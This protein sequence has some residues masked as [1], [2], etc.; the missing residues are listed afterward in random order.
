MSAM[1]LMKAV[2]EKIREIRVHLETK[3]ESQLPITT[4]QL[5]EE[6]Q[7]VSVCINK[8]FFS[9]RQSIR[10]SILQYTSVPCGRECKCAIAKRERERGRKRERIKRGR[11][12]VFSYQICI[13]ALNEYHLE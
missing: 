13:S 2:N 5:E 3:L 12:E 1:R 6:L 4:Y 7:N 8:D 10:A 11:K 9:I